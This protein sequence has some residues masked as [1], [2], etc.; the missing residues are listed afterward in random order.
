[1][2]KKLVSNAKINVGLNILGLQKNGYHELH[3][4]MLPISLSDILELEFTGKSGALKIYTENKYMPTDEENILHKIHKK[5]YDKSKLESQEIEVFI[6]KNIPMQSGLGGGSSN[7]AF[8]LMALNEYHNNFFGMD[9][10]INFS[11]KIGADIPFFL[12]NKPCEAKGIGEKLETFENNLTIK[13]LVVKPNFGVSTPIAFKIFDELPENKKPKFSDINQII[14][15]FESNNLDLIKPNIINHLEEALV[16]QNERLKS[17]R[18]ML[19][20]TGLEF[21][22]SGSGS[23][24]FSFVDDK[25]SEQKM[26]ELKCK[27]GQCKIFISNFL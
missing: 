20:K 25:F 11:K 26:S 17:F 14:S 23:A 27:L 6:D 18:N 19:D 2:K 13:L 4:T 22:M 15:G 16:I 12:V 7:G 8:F 5:F 9:E 21:F 1:M 3:M 10:L 24:F